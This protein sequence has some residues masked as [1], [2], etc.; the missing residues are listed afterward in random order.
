M[1]MLDQQ[2]RG[3]GR[4]LLGA[5][6]LRAS[7]LSRSLAG[8]RR[9]RRRR[10][11]PARR[12]PATRA[13]SCAV[14]PVVITSSTS[15]TVR[16]WMRSRWRTAKAPRTCGDGRRRRADLRRRRAMPR[17]HEG[18]T[19]VPSPANGAGEGR[20]WLNPATAVAPDG[21]EWE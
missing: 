17:Q 2:P 1:A 6:R 16:P 20:A 10:R 3:R 5:A 11:P 9:A 19:G 15:S 4:P 8:S 21:G 18:S 14:A 13:H 12:R 7:H